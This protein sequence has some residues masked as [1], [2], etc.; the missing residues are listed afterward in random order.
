MA[1]YGGVSAAA[2]AKYLALGGCN[3][4]C[5]GHSS[6]LCGLGCSGWLCVAAAG[7]SVSVFLA[8]SSAK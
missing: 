8:S 6:G 5:S 1:K 2:A 3:P 7:S 4:V